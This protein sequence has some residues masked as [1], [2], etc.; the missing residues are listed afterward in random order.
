[1]ARDVSRR[2]IPMPTMP[3]RRDF[4][5][6]SCAACGQAFSRAC[7]FFSKPM[8]GFIPQLAR[9]A[10]RDI[11]VVFALLPSRSAFRDR[12]ARI[13]PQRRGGVSRVLEQGH[14]ISW[15]REARQAQAPL[16]QS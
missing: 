9:S 13:T 7:H 11:S 8:G 15:R 4:D 3:A 1:M 16:R 2:F 12:S 6:P 5:P 14:A 10:G